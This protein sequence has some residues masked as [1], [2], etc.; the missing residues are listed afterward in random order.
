MRRLATATTLALVL[1]ATG[2]VFPQGSDPAKVAAY[3]KTLPEAAP[4]TLDEA[5][6]E[7][8][9]VGAIGCADHPQEEP[10]NRNSYLWLYAK[11]PQILEGYDKKRAFF[12][13]A[14]WHDAVGS[15]W[16]LLSMLHQD[17]KISL[18]AD[19]KDIEKT[20]LKDPNL[21]GEYSFFNGEKPAPGGNYFERP[22]GYAWL[23]KLYGELKIS[24]TDDDK[25]AAKALAPLAKWMSE[26]LVFY[27]YDLKFPFRSGIETN[28]AWTMRL[29]LDG[30][31]L[32]DNATLKTAVHDNALRL[33]GPDRNC[34]AGLE[35][36]NADL[37]S[38]CLT[39]AALVGRV[40]DQASYLRWLDAYLP[41]VYADSFQTYARA[42]DI[43][44]S[45]Q[46][47]IDAQ[48][49][50]I[51]E[52]HLIALTFQR[53]A[54]LFEI[55]FALPKDDPRIPVL[56]RLAAINARFGYEHLNVAGYEGQ[57]LLSTYAMLYENAASGPAPLA[58]PPKPKSPN[59]SSSATTEGN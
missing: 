50:Q 40:M 4:P 13:C 25:Q 43:S 31:N 22:F 36:Q 32:A 38:S 12:G 42:V 54:D 48:L 15:T 17:P 46:A 29:A 20:H 53:A 55:S 2:T 3:L 23:L 34:A 18:A 10:N 24:T 1:A 47:G 56:R 11:P 44:H 52:A 27:L 26:H 21:E 49:Q 9:A 35:P 41:P 19:I 51:A 57:H 6:R 14:N 37:V 59:G 39:E 5:H 28:T 33:F 30:A 16:M 7:T 58:P 45:N 8:L